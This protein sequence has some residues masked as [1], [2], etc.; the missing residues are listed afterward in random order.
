MFGHLSNP[1]QIINDLYEKLPQMTLLI[2][3]FTVHKFRKQAQVYICWSNKLGRV[4][5]PSSNVRTIKQTLKLNNG[6]TILT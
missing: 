2:P 4:T 5:L 1:L 3:V 6:G